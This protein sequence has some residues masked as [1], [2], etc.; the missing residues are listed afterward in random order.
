MTLAM[1]GFLA[2]VAIIVFAIGLAIGHILDY[3]EVDND[4]D[5]GEGAGPNASKETVGGVNGRP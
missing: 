5:D 3:L 2:T 1:A 4:G